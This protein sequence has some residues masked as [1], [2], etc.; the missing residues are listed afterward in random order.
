M[1]ALVHKTQ[2]I[3]TQPFWNSRMFT[4]CLDE[5]L[6]IQRRVLLAEEDDV[7]LQIDTDTRIVRYYEFK[8]DYN[9][10][11]EWLDGPIYQ[12]VEN[13]VVASF[14][15]RPLELSIAKE[16]LKKLLPQ[17]RYAKEVKRLSVEVTGGVKTFLID[18]DTRNALAQKSQIVG[19]SV[20]NW[21]FEHGWEQLAKSDIDSILAQIDQHVQDAYD[22]EYSKTLEID[23]CQ[24]L[25]EIDA[26]K[27]YNP[28]KNMFGRGF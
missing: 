5:D 22:W 8:P 21:K 4:V 1:Y 12:F 28:P 24:T 11:I 3:M 10:K 26:I 14:N 17:A 27:I 23:N 9:S 25:E 18:R 2:V 16:N 7:P 6:G 20:V 13:T 19:D 15:K